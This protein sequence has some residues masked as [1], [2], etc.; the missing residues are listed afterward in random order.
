M[1]GAFVFWFLRA[2]KT[3]KGGIVECEMCY[4]VFYLFKL[5]G[6]VMCLCVAAVFKF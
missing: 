5:P 3:E 1:I 2:L 4:A 6:S